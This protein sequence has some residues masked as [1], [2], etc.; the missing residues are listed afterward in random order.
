[1]KIQEKVKKKEEK[2]SATRSSQ[3]YIKGVALLLRSQ[4]WEWHSGVALKRAP[5]SRT[6]RILLF[7]SKNVALILMCVTRR[8]SPFVQTQQYNVRLLET[9][10]IKIK[11]DKKDMLSPYCNNVLFEIRSSVSKLTKRGHS[12]TTWTKFY[13]ILTTLPLECTIVTFYTI[14]NSFVSLTNCQVF[15]YPSIH[16][17]LS[18]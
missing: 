3:K 5:T 7:Y 1:M 11:N 6:H 17:H 16:L 12:L 15:P 2:K 18:T 8:N 14:S 13:P 4:F 9:V 10:S